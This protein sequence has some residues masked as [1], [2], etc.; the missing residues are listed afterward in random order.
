MNSIDRKT[1]SGSNFNQERE[2][3]ALERKRK[4]SL[5]SEAAADYDSWTIDVAGNFC[6]KNASHQCCFAGDP[7]V[8]L[9]SELSGIVTG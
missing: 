5:L 8:L 3:K 1:R 6:P 4:L 9:E 7:I 2:P